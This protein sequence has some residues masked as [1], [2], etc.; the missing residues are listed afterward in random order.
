MEVAFIQFAT[1]PKSTQI[2]PFV[3]ADCSSIGLSFLFVI[4]YRYL[5]PFS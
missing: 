4:I 2:E 1:R 5:I 3:I